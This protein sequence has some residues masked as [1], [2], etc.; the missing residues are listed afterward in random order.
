MKQH[1]VMNIKIK[2]YKMN[3]KVNKQNQQT[4]MMINLTNPKYYQSKKIYYY[5]IY[6]QKIQKVI[7]MII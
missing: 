4:K 6:H 1:K 7:Q 2:I 3:L 5:K